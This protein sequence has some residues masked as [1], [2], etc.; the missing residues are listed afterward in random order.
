[1]SRLR[2]VGVLLLV[3]TALSVTT[4]C[5]GLPADGP[6]RTE[7]IQAQVL[8][9]AP[10]DFTPGGPERD[11]EPVEIVRGYLVAMQATPINTSVARRFLTT[12]SSQSWV[13]EQG[14]TIYS[15]ETRSLRGSRVRL[16]LGNVVQLDG[17][18]SWLGKL[19][20]RSY[21]LEM[22]REDGQWRIDNPPDRLIIPETHFETRFTQYFLYF[23]DKAAQVL[24]PEPVYVPTGAQAS[25]I[26]VAGLLAGP[27]RE[28]LGVERTFLPARTRLD[29][30]SVP[31]TQDG[32]VEVP[33]S[34]EILDL[35]GE[36]LSLAFAQLAWTL[37]QVAG[38]ERLRVTVDGSPLDLPGSGADLSVNG[39]SEFDPAVSWAS[40]SLFGIR[41]GR[42]VT[43][44]GGEERRVS[45]PFGSL[46]LRPRRIAVDLAGEQ[47]AATTDEGSVLV[48]PRSRDVGTDPGLDD[49]RKVYSGGTDL[50]APVWD[51]YLQLWLLDRTAEGAALSVVRSG[52]ASPVTAPGITGEDVRSL[53][54]SRDGTRLVAE[55]AR[56][57]RERMLL[58][59]V[60]RD[61]DG[62]VRRVL[63]ADQVRLGGLDVRTIRDVAWR[64]P[65]SLALLTAPTQG[66]SQV[67][68]AKV[69]GSS[70]AAESTTD[71]EIFSGAARELVTSPAIGAPL[72]I[73]SPGGQMFALAVNGRWTGAGIRAGIRSPTFVG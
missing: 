45:G 23:F 35:D 10:V 2:R 50:L 18:G 63:P 47:V 46:D 25:T 22:V 51:P 7:Q 34:D 65:A 1:M 57:G 11:A 58:A 3:V 39:W 70:T 44:V 56:G 41:G 4:G 9:E 43:L 60:Q 19:G 68:V 38:T 42:V 5:T 72:Y 53:V 61:P 12:E 28:L 15:S 16:D 27:H 52:F 48:A 49:V 62:G 21:Q 31:V 14:T 32:V 37:R 66:T 55:V 36:R 71:A 69:D 6:V 73:R 33:L 17:R 54:L 8:D 30:I 64:T 67:V 24:V 26:L 29:D 59:R 20:D 40:Q 13:P